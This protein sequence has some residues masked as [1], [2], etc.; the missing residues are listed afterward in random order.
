MAST[1]S[2]VDG[3]GFEE[4]GQVGSQPT[5]LWIAGSITAENQISVLTVYGTTI[6]GV[7]INGVH[8][9][10]GSFTDPYGR[11]RSVGIDNATALY[12]YRIQAGS[13]KTGND[14]SGLVHFKTN[15][16]NAHWFMTVTPSTLT[17]PYLYQVTDLSGLVPCVSGIRRAS[18]CWI[19]G[20]SLTV[21]DWIAVGL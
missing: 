1:N 17:N 21:Y 19:Y 18:G 3:M 4:L 20:G 14:A 9:S 8:I 2:T 15:F 7:S 16:A 11:I 13:V 5:N 10:G 12:G 6:S